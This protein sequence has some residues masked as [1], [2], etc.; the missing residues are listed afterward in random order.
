MLWDWSIAISLTLSLILGAV[1]ASFFLKSLCQFKSE[2]EKSTL[3]RDVENL[4]L[5]MYVNF[6]TSYLF[7]IFNSLVEI[8]SKVFELPAI[9]MYLLSVL[10]TNRQLIFFVLG[11]GTMAISVHENGDSILN[12]LDN[13]YRCAVTPFVNNV[14]FSILH[15]VNYFWACFTPLWN[16]YFFMG[17]QLVIGTRLILTNCATSTLSIRSFLNGFA[18]FGITL[19]QETIKFMGLDDIDPRTNLVTNTLGF[20]NISYAWRQWFNWIPSALRCSCESLSPLIDSA[21]YGIFEV[22]HIDWIGH[23]FVNAFINAF[24]TFV[25]AIPPFLIYPNLETFWF[26]VTS[27]FLESG[28]LFDVWAKKVLEMLFSLIGNKIVVDV[29]DAFVGQATS[30]VIATFTHGLE[31]TANTTLHTILPFD[32]ITDVVFMQEVYSLD[33]SFA[34]LTMFASVSKVILAWALQTLVNILML[35]RFNKQCDGFIGCVEHGENGQCVVAC[36]ADGIHMFATDVQCPQLIDMQDKFIAQRNVFVAIANDLS[37]SGFNNNYKNAEGRLGLEAEIFSVHVEI[38]SGYYAVEIKLGSTVLHRD[39]LATE[40]SWLNYIGEVYVGHYKPIF[41]SVACAYESLLNLGFNSL[42]VAYDMTNSMIWDFFFSNAFQGL[43][44]ESDELLSVLT[45]YLGPV[46]GRDYDPPNFNKLNTTWHSGLREENSYKEWL[47]RNSVNRYNNINFHENVFYELDK[48]LLYSVAHILEENTFGKAAFNFIRIFPEA[49]KATIE[50]V[51]GFDFSQK[52]GCGRNYN[53]TAG[54]CTTSFDRSRAICATAAQN[55]NDANCVCN[56]ELELN[57]TASCQCIWDV[58]AEMDSYLSTNAVVHHCKINHFQFLFVFLR[59]FFEGFRNIIQSF[60]L[61]NTEFPANPNRCYVPVPDGFLDTLASNTELFLDEAQYFNPRLYEKVCK[62]TLTTVIA[63]DVGELFMR[64]YDVLF[65]FIKD[66]VKNILI[67]FGNMGT[68][69]RYGEIDIS[70]DDEICNVQEVMV[71]GISSLLG[72]RNSIVSSRDQVPV[73]AGTKLFFA[74]VDSINMFVAFLERT[75]QRF[76]GFVGGG[77]TL[78][79]FTKSVI[80]EISS[81]VFLWLR[82]MVKALGDDVGEI[83]KT[84]DIL[85]EIMGYIID[86]GFWMLDVVLQ[87][88]LLLLGPESVKAQ[89]T[90]NLDQ[91]FT[92]AADAIA[93]LFERLMNI[94]LA[95][96]IQFKNDITKVFCDVVCGISTLIPELWDGV[97]DVCAGVSCAAAANRAA[98]GAAVEEGVDAVGDWFVDTFSF[99]R[100]RLLSKPTLS[101][102]ANASLWTGTSMCDVVIRDMQNSSI[103]TI[104]KFERAFLTEC[105]HKRAQG[106]TIA[107]ALDLP[108]LDDIFYN[109]KKPYKIGYHGMRLAAIYLPWFFSNRTVK[110]L[111]YNIGEAGYDINTVLNFQKKMH[112]HAH[113]VFDHKHF[114]KLKKSPKNTAAHALGKMHHLMFKTNWDNHLKI[115]MKG[116]ENLYEA[117]NMT[118]KLESKDFRFLSNRVTRVIATQAEWETPIFGY[119]ADLQCPPDSLLCLNC[120]LLDNHIYATGKQL[121]HAVDFYEGPYKAIVEKNFIEFWENKSNYNRRYAKSFEAVTDT[122]YGT[123]EASLPKLVSFNYTEWFIGLFSSDRSVSEITEGIANFINGNY[124]GDLAS[125]AVQLFPY[126]LYYYVRAPFDASCD[127]P[128]IL[129]TSYD[130]RVGDGL[131]NMMIL[132]LVW[133]VFQLLVIRFNTC[134]SLLAYTTI[135]TLGNLIYLFTV[136]GF[137]PFCSGMQPSMYYNDILMWLDREVFL[138]CFCAY[139]PSLAKEPCAQQNCDTC[140][141]TLK[142]ESCH[143]VATGFTDLNLIWHF[144]FMVRWW[145][146]EFF[147]TIGS[148]TTWPIPYF[149]ELDGIKDLITD[150][151]RGRA[152]TAKEISCFWLNILTPVSVIISSYIAL[153]CAVPFIRIGVKVSKELFMLIVYLFLALINFSRTLF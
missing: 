4:R 145:A 140:D 33:K 34:H 73:K 139:I 57:I 25:K 152:V 122:Q 8:S 136:Y 3:E 71:S 35:P 23:H 128:K 91:L 37:T 84:I 41:N 5:S 43:Q 103:D 115:I 134:V 22:D 142:Y 127:D 96:L 44:L 153:L 151:N 80:R 76:I 10:W 123:F 47:T 113:H 21:M 31:T 124:T 81:F 53:G 24:Q 62:T 117:Q 90:A 14:I 98:A 66:W 38:V 116:V 85:H 137:N 86:V 107:Y 138:D 105:M 48:T 45:K 132:I 141:E 148:T 109:W 75:N 12:S 111:R 88:I 100:R 63:C 39:L 87:F 20:N 82:Q 131:F 129:Y 55:T 95:D 11:I 119:Y 112:V 64:L 19:L 61:G 135:F 60:Q 144:I 130:D 120:A 26:H 150:V 42:H 97:Q 102:L 93:T 27:F 29:P 146:P 2:R 51:V 28:I 74:F 89:A 121:E 94:V 67:I 92:E 18:T 49:L 72:I 69:N 126:D 114:E 17:R 77:A 54:S 143:D 78:K 101:Q 59:R 36:E 106:H 58:D 68:N 83:L 110:E 6:G 9:L 125:D 1:V 104:T 70:L 147:A 16:A 133:E 40:P 46:Y 15:V 56:P 108:Y 50:L 118:I 65:D 99:R 149:F 52:V 13:A 7:Q 32:R 30:H 79:S